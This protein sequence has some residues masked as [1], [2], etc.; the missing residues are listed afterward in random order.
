M[1]LTKESDCLNIFVLDDD[2]SKAARYH[3]DRHVVKMV[4]ETAQLL[5]FV[6][7]NKGGEN[8]PY[9]PSK[10]HMQHPCTLWAGHS[11]ENY[12]WLVK[13]GQELAKEYTYR[14]KKYHKAQS[15]IHWAERNI[16]IFK[17]QALSEHCLCMPEECKIGS[18]VESYREYYKKKKQHIA[19]W[20]NRE[21]PEWY[22]LQKF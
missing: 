20:K 15:V 7:H 1:A 2:V 18:V 17:N 13:F 21:I 8:I 6:H 19:V 5:S 10:A 4:T 16:P 22:D 12:L 9:K 11:L 14:Y 3:V